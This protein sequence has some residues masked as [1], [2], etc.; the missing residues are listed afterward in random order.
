MLLWRAAR[1]APSLVSPAS[2]AELSLEVVW[3]G[4]LARVSNVKPLILCWRNIS[5]GVWSRDSHLVSLAAVLLGAAG[6]A[7]VPV[8]SFVQG[9]PKTWG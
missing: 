6:A 4:D 3:R 1:P 5:L 2:L 8:P 7:L 9:S